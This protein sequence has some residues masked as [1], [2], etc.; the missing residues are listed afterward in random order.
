[1][2]AIYKKISLKLQVGVITIQDDV[3]TKLKIKS[4]NNINKNKGDN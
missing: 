4:V 1:M 2:D 3:N